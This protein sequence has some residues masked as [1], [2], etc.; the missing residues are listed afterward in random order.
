ME[1]IYIYIKLL[2]INQKRQQD[3]EIMKLTVVNLTKDYIQ[4][5]KGLIV[6]TATT[7]LTGESQAAPTRQHKILHHKKTSKEKCMNRASDK[8]T[9]AKSQLNS[10]VISVPG[11]QDT[12]VH[13][14]P[15]TM[16]AFKQMCL[17]FYYYKL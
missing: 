11:L 17:L 9:H 6:T 15:E 4:T 14:H 16:G 1:H 10:L 13:L 7:L 8:M 2:T 5:F 12:K 3:E